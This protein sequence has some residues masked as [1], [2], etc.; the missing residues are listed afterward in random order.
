MDEM[1]YLMD[2]KYCVYNISG[3]KEKTELRKYIIILG[4]H[5]KVISEN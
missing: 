5:S 2:D 1:D 3:L 4:R